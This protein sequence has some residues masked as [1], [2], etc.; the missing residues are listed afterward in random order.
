M[1]GGGTVKLS[2]CLRGYGKETV[3]SPVFK[4]S[5][6]ILELMIPLIVAKI[7]DYAIP[8]KDTG[9]I[10]KMICLI[11]ALGAV[12]FIFAVLGQYFAAKS[13][14]GFG[15]RMREAIFD[16]IE[17]L[18]YSDLDRA[19]APALI[20]RLNSD[21]AQAQSGLNIFLRLVLRSPFIV[22]GAVVMAFSI[23]VRS[24]LIFSATV[25]ALMIVSLVVVLSGVPAFRR[26][27]GALDRVTGLARENMTG[28]RVVRAFVREKEEIKA[29]GEAT[30]KHARLQKIAGNVSGALN[31]ATYV[32]INTALI[33]ILRSGAVR[34]DSGSMTQGQVIALYNYMIGMLVELLKLAGL[35]VMLSRSWACAG[36]VSS[37]LNEEIVSK[38]ETEGGSP[39]VP[40]GNG[41]PRV[42]FENVSAGYGGAAHALRNVSFSVYPGQTV[43][44]IGSTGSGKTTL[45]DLIPR[46]YD[47][48]S[49]SV[50][51]DGTDVRETDAVSLRARCGVVPQRAVLFKGTL[52][53]NLL[54]GNPGASDEEI[55]G[56]MRLACID[57]LLDTDG[58]LDSPVAQYGRNFSGGQR[59]RLT[60]ARALVRR[61]DILIL[62]DSSS[63]LDY[64]TEAKLRRNIA[65][66][67]YRPTVFIV[68]QR[69]GSVMDADL[70]IVLEDGDV[71]GM[72]RHDELLA[73]CSVY[74]EIHNVISGDG[75]VSG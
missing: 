71:V 7:I 45:V 16:K 19:T 56:A 28:V 5:E 29:F 66:L 41:V 27:Q 21:S 12:G 3:L 58:G 65:S 6:A 24:A 17:A 37:F 55:R 20:N 10:V 22:I 44:V 33:L 38:T 74:R 61:P 48:R 46:F 2:G 67:D 43:G 40:K 57:E 39:S 9:Y 23:D 34:I 70:I 50:F 52:R 73:S 64:A 54:F 14:A 60:V 36:R 59:Q 4:L 63:A 15:T 1:K 11:A 25:A 32:I 51:V 26:A 8:A 31:P 75:E 53:D 47:A 18:S 62:D 42:R 68:S 72:G 13:S 30:G 35:I 69:T 49:G